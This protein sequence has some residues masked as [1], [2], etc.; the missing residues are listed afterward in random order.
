[1]AKSRL[2]KAARVSKSRLIFVAVM[3]IGFLYCP[4]A[5]GQFCE[6]QDCYVPDS[7]YFLPFTFRPLS[8][9]DSIEVRVPVYLWSDDWANYL[10]SG[11]CV[12]SGKAVFDTCYVGF[13]THCD[14]EERTLHIT[15]DG[16]TCSIGAVCRSNYVLPGSGIL[17][18]YTLH[19]LRG[20]NVRIKGR[21]PRLGELINWWDPLYV[22]LDT[23]FVV[24][25]E[26]P[27]MPGDV[28]CSQAV[29]IS[30]AV[31]LINYIFGGGCAP[32]SPNAADVN[33]SC[34]ISISDVVYLINYIFA[35]GNAPLPG[36]VAP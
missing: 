8:C 25:S 30:D 21:V 36:C 14:E 4:K 35:G 12:V 32:C 33:S 1:M 20:E 28:N 11:C 29:S 18:E 27:S 26:F 31:F 17:A 6:N 7:V 16:D 24:P 9:Y 13:V 10:F 3:L 23:N 15:S 22:R 5:S 2:E 34:N 19:C